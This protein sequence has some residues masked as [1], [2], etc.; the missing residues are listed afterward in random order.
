M[1]V[2]IDSP[3][4]GDQLGLNFTVEGT[5]ELDRDAKG[6]YPT[7]AKVHVDVTDN[8][9]Q[10]VILGSN[11]ATLPTDEN[12]DVQATGTWSTL[13]TLSDDA[14]DAVIVAVLQQQGIPPQNWSTDRVEGVDFQAAF[15]IDSIQIG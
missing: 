10:P 4:P 5:Y 9:Q 13:I 2:E 7:T 15:Q 8:A 3:G 11:D 1:P 12:G 6:K 14:P